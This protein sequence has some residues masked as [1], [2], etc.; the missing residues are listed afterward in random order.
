MP[1]IHDRPKQMEYSPVSVFRWA[2]CAEATVKGTGNL[3]DLHSKDEP[4]AVWLDLGGIT[5]P[6]GKEE[7]SP[8]LSQG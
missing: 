1:C 7:L 6:L 3:Q 4:P 8:S 5:Q 2:L